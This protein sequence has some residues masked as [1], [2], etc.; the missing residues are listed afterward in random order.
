MLLGGVRTKKKGRFVVSLKPKNI[1][2]IIYLFCLVEKRACIAVD[3]LLGTT[4]AMVL[5]W[6]SVKK[7]CS[8]NRWKNWDEKY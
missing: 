8:D 7:K 2:C 4:I 1:I 6:K 5:S 3:V